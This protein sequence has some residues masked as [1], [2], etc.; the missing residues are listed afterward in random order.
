M[1][2]IQMGAIVDLCERVCAAHNDGRRRATIYALLAYCHEASLCDH[3]T[4]PAARVAGQQPLTKQIISVLHQ[5]PERVFRV[6]DII[7]A[8]GF[9]GPRQTLLS[10]LADLAKAGRVRR[11]QFG[12]YSAVSGQMTGA[13]PVAVVADG[14]TLAAAPAWMRRSRVPASR[15]S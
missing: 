2:D 6:A 8:T 14:G 4:P 3:R 5:E 13:S 1:N 10:T 7:A 12:H 9:S 11:V 15:F